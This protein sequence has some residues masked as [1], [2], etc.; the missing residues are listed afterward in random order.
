MRCNERD[1][2]DLCVNC[3][4]ELSQIFDRS[5]FTQFTHTHAASLFLFLFIAS[6]LFTMADR[7]NNN[8]NNPRRALGNI[9]GNNL[10]HNGGPM[11]VARNPRDVDQQRWTPELIA[12]ANMGPPA[13][14]Y[15]DGTLS[16]L[17]HDAMVTIYDN[18]FDDSV[19]PFCTDIAIYVLF[20]AIGII[21]NWANET[22]YWTVEYLARMQTFDHSFD[23]QLVHA[24]RDACTRFYRGRSAE[25]VLGAVAHHLT[26]YQALQ[27]VNDNDP[28]IDADENR[29]WSDP[30]VLVSE[31]L[32]KK[33]FGHHPELFHI[34]RLIMDD[35]EVD[36]A[37]DRHNQGE[38]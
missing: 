34:L 33:G 29:W 38:D 9:Q 23:T 30:G 18:N 37:P 15:P 5:K 17:F 32:R 14:I 25:F 27:Q 13:F 12:R 28:T 10:I 35:D 16:L 20:M 36:V 4:C 19:W 21:M 2:C 8:N 6:C 3:V 31:M 22:S 7:A 26:I 24:L 11:V 1:V